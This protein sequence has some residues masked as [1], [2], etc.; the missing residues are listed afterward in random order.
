YR[1]GVNAHADRWRTRDS[2]SGAGCPG[3]ES[4]A[5]R[6][7]SVRPSALHHVFIGHNRSA[8][9]HG[10]QRRRNAAAASQGADSSYRSKAGRRGFLLHDLR[11]DDVELAGQL[12]D[13]KSTR[14]NSSHAL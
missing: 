13:R 8:E 14:L 5:V 6:A 10:A 1:P 7:F 3:S 11:L 4:I 2:I 12:A 9:V